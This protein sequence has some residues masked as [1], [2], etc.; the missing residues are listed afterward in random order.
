MPDNTGNW[1]QTTPNSAN[2]Q[3]I[4]YD[5]SEAK[6][7]NRFGQAIN[8]KF[9]AI[10]NTRFKLS[11]HPCGNG[12]ANAGYVSV[13]LQNDSAHSVIVNC[14][15][16]IEGEEFTFDNQM[17]DPLGSYG[18]SQLME[19]SRVDK[20]LDITV[21]TIL[22]QEEIEDEDEGL[23]D[24]K[25]MKKKLQ[26]VGGDLVKVK[27]EMKE[28]K[29]EIKEMKEELKR[30]R[31]KA[32]P[33][34]ECPICFNEMKPP[35]RIIQCMKGHKLCEPCHNRPEVM[36]CPSNCKSGFMG[37]DLGMEAF[38]EHQVRAGQQ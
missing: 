38:I 17:I 21:D 26:G 37:R 29:D 15:V 10:R 24:R 8:S 20:D 33:I 7:A 13:Y 4:I 14:S 3:F 34:P 1:V 32:F 16:H 22:Q 23:G 35:T 28:I 19:N 27:G 31:G 12:K 18:W 6:L 2:F 30:S 5:F 9:F 11:V 25:Y 36:N